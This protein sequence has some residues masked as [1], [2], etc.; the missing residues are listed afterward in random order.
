MVLQEQLASYVITSGGTLLDAFEVLP[1]PRIRGVSWLTWAFLTY[2]SLSVLS[3]GRIVGMA[4]ATALLMTG[5]GNLTIW[6][7]LIG[8]VTAA[9]FRRGSYS[10]IER[11]FT[12]LVG[13]FSACQIIAVFLTQRTGYTI[14][15]NDLISGLG[16]DLPPEGAYLA[17]A[18][19]GVTGVSG[20]ELIYYTYWCLEKGYG[21]Y[22]GPPDGSLEWEDRARKWI[23]VMRKDVLLTA[24]IYTTITVAFYLLGAAI[25]HRTQ[26][27]LVQL[28]GIA[29]AR[30]LSDIFTRSF[31][32]WSYYL[33]MGGAFLILFSTYVSSCASI[34][35]I[36]VNFLERLEWISNQSRSQHNR[37]LNR[38]SVLVA[39][40]AVAIY[41]VSQA[42]VALILFFGGI[43]SS[44]F[45][46]LMGIVPIYLWR[47]KSPGQLRAGRLM[48]SL[49]WV[50]TI[51]IVAV[52]CASLYLQI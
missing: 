48:H 27:D 42:P 6:V 5:R 38:C 26:A 40:V 33:F 13:S 8:L 3:L 14:G 41:L 43:L 36:V 35:R 51:L 49:L 25:L 16:L 17:L 11:L 2:L 9:F 21:R 23:S 29:T 18:V 22:I 45:L 10:R 24:F 7:I 20:S 28:E 39:V 44:L 50:S 15:W 46:P 34:S 4:A 19:F 32:A 52:L 47:R 30:A 31:G 1:G 12:V 37:W